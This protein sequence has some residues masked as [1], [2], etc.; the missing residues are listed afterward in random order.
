M[1]GLLEGVFDFFPIRFE[2]ARAL[3]RVRLGW[4]IAAWVRR[5]SIVRSVDVGGMIEDCGAVVKFEVFIGGVGAMRS[6]KWALA[7]AKKDGDVKSPLQ[8]TR[9]ERGLESTVD[10]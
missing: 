10:G 3:G 4:D 9:G 6:N 8:I 5:G 7:D 2:R 1:R